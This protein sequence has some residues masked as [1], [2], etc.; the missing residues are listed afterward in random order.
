MS[1]QLLPTVIW[2]GVPFGDKDAFLDW[3]LAHF[4]THVELAKKTFTAIRT[5]DELRT[6]PFPHA[7]MHRDLSVALSSSDDYDFASYDL[8]DKDSFANFMLNHALAHSQLQTL[9][10]L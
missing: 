7:Q 10:G 1:L 3:S 5:L 8:T 2:Q 4:L 6:D 9:A